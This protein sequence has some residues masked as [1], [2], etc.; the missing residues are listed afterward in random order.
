MNACTVCLVC[1]AV[2]AVLQGCGGGGGGSPSTPTPEPTPGPTPF[3][4]GIGGFCYG[5]LPCSRG[6]PC[7]KGLPADDIMQSGYAV[8]W[9]P[10]G[11]DDLGA[12]K[13]LN[14]RGVRLYHSI[15]ASENQSHQE[16]LDYAHKLGMRV[17]PG[18]H[19]NMKCPEMDCHDSWKEAVERGFQNGYRSG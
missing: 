17:H 7:D 16:F 19:T 15:G 2:A 13:S 12:M 11:R 3:G 4:Y 9:G 5:A 8:Q 18:I 6:A 14:G 1:L 10:D